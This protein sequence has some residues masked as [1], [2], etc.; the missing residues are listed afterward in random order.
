MSHWLNQ[1]I[2]H[3]YGRF[4]SGSGWTPAVNLYEQADQYCVVVDLAGMQVEQVDLR[5][6][7][8][9]LV[10]Q[11]ER[12]APQPPDACSAMRVHL[13]EIDHGRF[14]REIE[15]PSDVDVQRISASYRNG[16]LWVR[17][18]KKGA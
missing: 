16:Y 9:V 6:E 3:G 13:M 4:C 5:A 2:G 1:V 7:K 15:L 11:G 17:M 14:C 12:A 10:L 18:P 8:D